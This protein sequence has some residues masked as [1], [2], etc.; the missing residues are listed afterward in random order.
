VIVWAEAA[1][2]ARSG[3]RFRAPRLGSPEPGLPSRLPPDAG[4]PATEQAGGLTTLLEEPATA[5][6]GTFVH[7]TP[8]EAHTLVAREDYEKVGLGAAAV[9]RLL[10]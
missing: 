1:H 2:G 9:E 10:R 8:G 3:R 7:E 5:N 4:E 6:R